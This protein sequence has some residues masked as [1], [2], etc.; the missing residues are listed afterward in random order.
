[1]GMNFAAAVDFVNRE[2]S[3]TDSVLEIGSDRGEASTDYLSKLAQQHD[4]KFYSVDLD[5]D[6]IEANQKL[7]VDRTI[8]FH[9]CDGTV[10]LENNPT[11][12]FS[13]V[14]LDNFDWNVYMDPPEFIQKQQRRYLELGQVMNNLNSQRAHLSQAIKLLPLLT[15]QSAVMLDDT[16]LKT[17]DQA[18]M[19]KGMAVIPLLLDH[20]FMLNRFDYGV[21]MIRKS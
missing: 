8:E 21:I 13:V 9:C 15:K 4:Q 16:W 10:W 11:L 17:E 1:M 12:R 3:V 18:Y 5:P 7:Y 2:I 19:G 6:V 20:G 14:L